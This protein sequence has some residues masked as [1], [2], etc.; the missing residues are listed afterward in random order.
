MIFV[1]II[2]CGVSK[3]LCLCFLGTCSVFGAIFML[4]TFSFVSISAFRKILNSY[5]FWFY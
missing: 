4:A 3:Y 2:Y 1:G 5:T